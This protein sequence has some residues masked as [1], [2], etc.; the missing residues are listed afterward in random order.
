MAPRETAGRMRNRSS[1]RGAA[2]GAAKSPSRKGKTIKS[3]VS[4]SKASKVLNFDSMRKEIKR[5]TAEEEA[6]WPEYYQTVCWIT[7]LKKAQD[8]KS[9]LW[10]SIYFSTALWLWNWEDYTPP[11]EWQRTAYGLV[12]ITNVYFS[13][14]G[15]VITHN[16][17]HQVSK[18][19]TFNCQYVEILELHLCIVVIPV[20]AEWCVGKP[21]PSFLILSHLTVALAP[22]IAII[23]TLPFN[24][25]QM[26]R[27]NWANK[28]IQVFLSLTYGHPVSSYVPGHNLSHHKY[29]QS[30]KDVM[31]THLLQVREYGLCL[32]AIALFYCCC[33]PLLLVH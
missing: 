30:R 9:L 25:Q 20:S 31:N 3:A 24:L 13:F 21:L 10:M 14:L 17:M 28:L 18:I 1:S 22:T 15:A 12:F 33:V 11:T 4:A 7:G 8:L 16:T 29:T 26:F 6:Q 32:K 2:N 27:W 5:I 23:L 19:Y